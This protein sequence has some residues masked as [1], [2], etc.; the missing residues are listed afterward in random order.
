MACPRTIG[1]VG[2]LKPW[3]G[4]ETLLNAL[5]LLNA[6]AP[7][8]HRVLLVGDGPQAPRLHARASR[9]RVLQRVKP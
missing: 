8:A 4:V 3:H 1:F 7:G 5:A 6:A 9:R 2:T